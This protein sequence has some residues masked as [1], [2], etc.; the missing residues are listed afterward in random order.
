VLLL[1]NVS[2]SPIFDSS[3]FGAVT[4]RGN[5]SSWSLFNLGSPNELML[6]VL[7]SL[8]TVSALSDITGQGLVL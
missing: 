5:L 2:V 4:L 6:E 1:A 8:L 7:G 3:K